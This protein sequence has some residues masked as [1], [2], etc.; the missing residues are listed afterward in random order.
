MPPAPVTSRTLRKT[1]SIC[2]SANS[3]NEEWNFHPRLSNAGHD[4]KTCWR[5]NRHAFSKRVATPFLERLTFLPVLFDFGESA[6][7]FLIATGAVAWPLELPNMNGAPFIFREA[8]APSST[9]I[10]SK[11]WRP[12]VI[13]T[14]FVSMH[15]I[16]CRQAKASGSSCCR[17]GM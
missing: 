6:D 8:E 4:R 9:L 10:N 14:E 7:P 11:P 2:P 5:R 16:K 3:G 1:Y 15:S 17:C 13:G 12:L